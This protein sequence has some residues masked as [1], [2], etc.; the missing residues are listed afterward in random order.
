MMTACAWSKFVCNALHV[1]SSTLLN[2]PQPVTL[3]NAPHRSGRLR[4]VTQKSSVCCYHHDPCL[5]RSSIILPPGE[6]RRVRL[7]AERSG[8][9]RRSPLAIWC[10]ETHSLYNNWVYGLVV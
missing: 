4:N 5:R 8:A 2:A 9:E 6:R 7:E 1:G 10:L 3:R